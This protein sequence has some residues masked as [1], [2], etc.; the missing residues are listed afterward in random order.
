MSSS[1]TGLS[2]GVLGDPQFVGLLGQS[3]QVHGIDGAVYSLIAE[4]GLLVNARFRYLSSGRCPALASARNCWSHPGSYLG[5]VGAVSAEGGRLHMWRAAR[6]TSGSAA[7]RR[8][9]SCSLWAA[10]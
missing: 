6:G 10:T 3:Y 8:T 2:A 7:S 5:E 9:G 1:S 4:R